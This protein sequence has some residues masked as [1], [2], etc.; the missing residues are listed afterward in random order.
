VTPAASGLSSAEAAQRLASFGPNELARQEDASAWALLARQFTGA[1]IWLLLAACGVSVA[2]GEVADAAAIGA[3]IVLNALVGFFQEHRAERAVHALRALSAPRARVL[4]DGRSALIPAREVVV[5]DVLELEA[6]DV[7]AADARLL[8]AH[9]LQV[10]EALLTGESV[11]VDKDTT[12]TPADAPLAER[13]DRVFLGTAVASGRGV[14]EVVAIGMGTEMGHIARL[15]ATTET[16]ATPLERQLEG[17]GRT[18]LS[19]C[20][21]IVGLVLLLG[22]W[23]GLPWIDVLLSSVSLAVAAVP[24]GL[25]AIVTIALA[26][27]VQ[28]MAARHALVRRLAAVETLGCTTVICTDKTGTLT[29]GRME[30]RDLWAVDRGKILFAAAAC[31]DAQLT[32][33]GGVG[34]PTEVAI[35]RAAA[36]RGVARAAIERERPRVS[37]TPFDSRRRRMSVARA[38]GVLYVKGAL[39]ALLPL[40]SA[41]TEGAVAAATD[42]AE[43]GLRV[44]AVAVGT[45]SDERELRLLGLLG[46]ADPP[47]PETA[48]AVA[49]ARAAGVRTVMITGDHP[50]TAAAIACEVGIVAAI[51]DAGAAVHARATAEQKIEIV[52]DLKTSGAI[53]AMTGDGVNDAP[54]L[55]AAHI[56]VAMGRNGTEVA[57]EASDVI[58]TDDNF[59]TIVAAIEEGRGI[60]ANIRKTLVYLLAGNVGELA[61]MLAASVMGLPLP[62]LPLHLLWINLVTDG[63]PAL[64]LVMDPPEPDLMDR[65]PRAPADPMLGAAQWRRILGISLVEGAVVLSAFA[66]SLRDGDV[67]EARAFAFSTLV[68]CELFRAFGARSPRLLYWQVGAFTNLPLLAVVMV[69]V[70]LQVALPYLPFTRALFDLPLPSIVDTTVSLGLGLIPVTVIE[71]IKLA[72]SALGPRPAVK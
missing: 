34:D 67:I 1:M 27:G 3:I 59:A 6:G 21:G 13:R 49:A 30:L 62:L 40:C 38:D 14:A 9:A 19:I 32:A 41:G 72:R 46:L 2:L 10:V 15:L 11:P 57:R 50:V 12:P 63:L 22:L 31:S 54:A 68:F 66:L 58:L 28:R 39:E 64:A 26:L 20:L 55:R 60:Y 56:G 70:L 25:P 24:E 37:E 35:L 36:E 45:G 17:L 44:L 8:E 29:T 53:V 65:P 71:L 16:T 61:V 23:R 5:G 7:V 51:E 47:R 69:S 4:R 42:M 18:L 43:S 33:E 52:R 48:A